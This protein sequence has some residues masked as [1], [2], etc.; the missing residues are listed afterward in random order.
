MKAFLFAEDRYRQ[1]PGGVVGLFDATRPDCA[2]HMDDSA[3]SH[4]TEECQQT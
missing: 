3:E 2:K 1:L 4:Y